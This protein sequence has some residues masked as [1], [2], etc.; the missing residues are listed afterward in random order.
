HDDRRLGQ[1]RQHEL[2]VITYLYFDDAT[3]GGGS[4]C[5]IRAA[6]RI[7]RCRHRE[8]GMINYCR[9]LEIILD[10]IG[11]RGT[12]WGRA[13]TPTNHG[14]SGSFARG[15]GNKVISV[16]SPAEVNQTKHRGQKERQNDRV[17]HQVGAP[18][19]LL[20]PEAPRGLIKAKQG[21]LCEDTASGCSIQFFPTS[22]IC[23]SHVNLQ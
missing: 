5:A 20:T 17:L 8:L 11:I 12:P 2:E 1:E 3:R 7:P 14:I 19:V 9:S 16:K 10:V 21:G 13:G 6:V 4:H 18:L 15:I 23:A 22:C